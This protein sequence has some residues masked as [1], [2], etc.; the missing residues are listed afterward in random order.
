MTPTIQ[1]WARIPLFAASLGAALAFAACGRSSTELDP[2]N[3][4]EAPDYSAMIEAAPPRLAALYGEGGGLLDGGLDAYERQVA[5]LRGFPIVV[6]KWASWCGPCR[7]EFPHLQQQAAERAD[8]VAFIGID[9][10]DSTDAAE[11]F[12]RDHPLPTRASPTPTRRS[13]A[14]S[15][16]SRSS[17][18][19]SSM[20]PRARSSTSVAAS[21]RPRRS[22]PPTSIATRLQADSAGAWSGAHRGP[23]GAP[24]CA[25]PRPAGPVGIIGV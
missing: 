15:A 4:A 7:A 21:T 16:P 3:A 19:R 18:R 9:S 6:N 22:S 17:P 13:S 2:G 14:R 8:E 25:P 1:I 12:L 20:T 10:D 24:A 23:A 11:T 5:E